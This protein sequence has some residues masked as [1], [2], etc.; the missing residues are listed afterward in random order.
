VN[1]ME[2][3]QTV[4][5]F[6][7]LISKSINH[8]Y[9]NRFIDN[10]IYEKH[11]IIALSAIT[12]HEENDESLIH[13]TMLVQIALNT[14]DQIKKNFQSEGNIK[15][16]QL[17]VLAGDYYSGIYYD[18][19]AHQGNL[20]FIYYLS[21]GINEL[22]QMKMHVF[23]QA[24]PDIYAF[25]KDY[26]EIQTGLITKVAQFMK[27]E[28]TISYL[29]NWLMLKHIE[30]EISFFYQ[31]EQTFLQQLLVSNVQVKN[32]FAFM[33]ETL[34]RIHAHYQETLVM[35]N[36]LLPDIDLYQMKTYQ[37]A[38]TSSLEEGLS[39]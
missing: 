36:S 21:S 16:Q 30:Q 19:L 39:K 26:M 10:P 37:K 9:L 25:L 17:T 20:P 2:Y 35:Y 6:T 7:N 32:S 5:Y 22:T 15:K 29:A 33:E 34:W 8:S 12:E 4:D 28:N 14:H 1:V 38:R 23:Y 3:I 31:G 27:Q 18:I 24:Y 11:K 13:T